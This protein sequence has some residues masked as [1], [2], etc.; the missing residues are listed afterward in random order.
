MKISIGILAHNEEERISGTLTSLFA[1]DL[2]TKFETE[3]VVVPNGC[4]DAT[5][6]AARMS[7]EANRATWSALGTARVEELPVAGKA[8]AWNEFVHR[9]SSQDADTLVLMDADISFLERDTLSRLVAALTG[10]PGA[11]VSVDQPLKRIEPGSKATL[12]QRVLASSTPPID[13][14]DVPI[15]GQLYCAYSSELRRI[16]LPREI[17]VDDGFV[18]AMLL[19]RCFTAREDRSRIRAS[20]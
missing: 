1:Q 19:T 10:S 4:S 14:R 8:N 6:E 18:R 20:I 5:A 11:V 13:P 7:I 15:C 12:I 2:F 3:L 16:R 17:Q 9:L